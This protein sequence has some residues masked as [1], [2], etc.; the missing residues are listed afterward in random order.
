MLKIF[1]LKAEKSRGRKFS[2]LKSPL[3]ANPSKKAKKCESPKDS[4]QG[5]A[6]EVEDEEQG[7]GQW[8]ASRGKSLSIGQPAQGIAKATSGNMGG[9][10]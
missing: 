3:E 10:K 9:Y 7:R 5:S 6:D 4:C 8:F 1:E 2:R